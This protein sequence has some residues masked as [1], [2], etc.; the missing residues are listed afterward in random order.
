MSSGPHQ[1]GD[2]VRGFA[3]LRGGRVAAPGDGLRDAVPQ[4]VFQQAQ[5]HRLQRPGHRRHLGQDVDAVLVVLDHLLQ[6]ADLA[7]D[8][9]QPLEVVLFVLGVSVHAAS[10]LTFSSYYYTPVGYMSVRVVS[11]AD[12]SA[13]P[14]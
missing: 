13:G 5:R 12:R 6:P 2:R 4:M 10:A 1:A 3:D 9:P 8:P 7:L 14:G 11:R